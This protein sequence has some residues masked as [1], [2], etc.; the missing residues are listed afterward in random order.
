MVY[1]TLDDALTLSDADSADMQSAT[2]QLTDKY[3]TGK[4]YLRL[5][6]GGPAGITVGRRCKL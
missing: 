2:V 1:Q 3:E 6:A 4:D 5:P